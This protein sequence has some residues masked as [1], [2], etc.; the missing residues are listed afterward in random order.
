ME[1]SEGASPAPADRKVTSTSPFL[2]PGG[3][4][5]PGRTREWR[6]RLTVHYQTQRVSLCEASIGPS[7][8]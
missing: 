4:P 7:G 6:T 2:E 5:L 1:V 3:P 8:L